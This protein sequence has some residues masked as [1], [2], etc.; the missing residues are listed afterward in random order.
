MSTTISA[1][2]PTLFAPT[3]RQPARPTTWEA[4]AFSDGREW[5]HHV[6]HLR[7]LGSRHKRPGGGTN[8]Q[9]G[10]LQLPRLGACLDRSRRHH[11]LGCLRPSGAGCLQ[12]TVAG[13]TSTAT[14][15]TAGNLTHQVDPGDRWTDTYYDLFGRACRVTQTLPGSPRITVKDQ[16][17]VFDSLSRATSGSDNLQELA[18]S[19]S[20]PL[21][22]PAARTGVLTVG[23]GADQVRP[24]SRSA[25]TAW[26]QAGRRWLRAARRFR[27]FFAPSTPGT[28]AGG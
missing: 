8:G 11:L 28:T 12:S 18:S 15:D 14:Y 16:T 25:P 22:T 3:E 20:Y 13:N 1:T 9:H 21:N 5:A 7:L 24:L 17:A 23:S 27:H 19:W 10:D 26:R 6:F 4:G 2:S